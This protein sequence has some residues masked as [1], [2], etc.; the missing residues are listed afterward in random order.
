MFSA[1]TARVADRRPVGAFRVVVFE[2]RDADARRG[3]ARAR[4]VRPPRRL[5]EVRPPRRCRAERAFAVRAPRP[6]PRRR[7][8]RLARIGVDHTERLGEPVDAREVGVVRRGV[9]G[10][11]RPRAARE[12]G[13]GALQ[14]CRV[15][16][17]DVQAEEAAPSPSGACALAR[18]PERANRGGCDNDDPREGSLRGSL[19]P[20]RAPR[21]AASPA[22]VVEAFEASKTGGA[23]H[24]ESRDRSRREVRA[25][26][27]ETNRDRRAARGA[28]E[29][30]R[31]APRGTLV[32]RLARTRAHDHR[33]L[34]PAAAVPSSRL[35]CR[36]RRARGRATSV[37]RASG[38]GATPSRIL[39]PSSA[40]LALALTA[41]PS[42][43]SP[44]RV[45][46]SFRAAPARRAVVDGVA[47]RPVA[48][49]AARARR[50]PTR[51]G[52][53]RA[54]GRLGTSSM[55]PSRAPP[56][57]APAARTLSSPR[58][59]RR[60]RVDAA[61]AA[62]GGEDEGPSPRIE[63]TRAVGPSPS[64]RR[65]R[66][67]A[68]RA[69]GL[70]RAAARVSAPTARR[71]DGAAAASTPPRARCRPRD[72]SFAQATGYAGA[73]HPGPTPTPAPRPP[74]VA[75]SATIA[76]FRASARRPAG[77]RRRRPASHLLPCVC[78]AVR[79]EHDR[80]RARRTPTP[81]VFACARRRRLLTEAFGVL[82]RLLP[83]TGGLACGSPSAQRWRGLGGVFASLV[84]Q[85]VNRGE[86]PR[87]RAR[88]GPMGGSVCA[89]G[90]F[91]I[92]ALVGLS[93]RGR[94]RR[95]TF[96]PY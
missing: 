58:P 83:V 51:G 23:L 80:R 61:A 20:S 22:R 79:R 19:C 8:R 30:A 72:A 53:A 69:G 28:L 38:S 76:R 66:R 40:G 68:G 65:R 36:T 21:G 78:R 34:F 92:V 4:G 16:G 56:T 14:A 45:R 84:P 88:G 90:A 2:A 3:G 43:P 33:D 32:E 48:A 87:V 46:V 64:S 10:V 42:P 60:P 77:R 12:R 91:L 54:R 6:C 47:G 7:R 26:N 75:P 39:A 49:R 31:P 41:P 35:S 55:A 1:R 44:P 85:M 15:N 82:P 62:E 59:R 73:A 81:S 96:F 52:G 57:R 11:G 50:G 18:A 74:R 67:R 94:A 71:L 25:A 89:L 95:R 29:E 63:G 9:R 17:P 13:G 86:R 27:N 5:H 24:A 37:A 70:A 93:V